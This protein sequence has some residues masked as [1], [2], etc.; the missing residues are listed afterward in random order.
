[1]C[2]RQQVQASVWQTWY[3]HSPY[4][5]PSWALEALKG[6]QWPVFTTTGQRA[7]SQEITDVDLDTDSFTVV[8]VKT[9]V[10]PSRTL[11]TGSWSLCCRLST[12]QNNADD[13]ARMWHTVDLRIMSGQ[14][15]TNTSPI[16]SQVPIQQLVAGVPVNWQIAAADEDGDALQYRLAAP[17]EQGDASSTQP[18]GLTIDASSGI[19]SFT[20]S[21][22][23]HSLM[24]VVSDGQSDIAVDMLLQAE[25]PVKHCSNACTVCTDNGDCGGSTC[26]RNDNPQFIEPTSWL[27]GGAGAA[28]STCFFPDTLSTL[29]ATVQDTGN[30]C[31]A[32]EM[33]PAQLPAG[34]VV[35]LVNSSSAPSRGYS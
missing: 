12:F 22:G 26:G 30:E 34:A 10:F 20:P 15:W 3:V 33:Q 13:T 24:I 29:Q 21:I 23:M 1:M 32:V 25:A 16:V 35:S 8:A 17:S 31:I 28:A 27:A 2:T 14:F 7:V 11:Y 9:V 4:K 19:I 18:A 5:L 6:R